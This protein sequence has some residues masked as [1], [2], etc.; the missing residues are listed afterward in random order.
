MAKK[1]SSIIQIVW[2][3]WHIYRYIYTGSCFSNCDNWERHGIVPIV[4][5]RLLEDRTCRLTYQGSTRAVRIQCQDLNTID[6]S[7]HTFPSHRSNLAILVYHQIANH[8]VLIFLNHRTKHI[9]LLYR[10]IAHLILWRCAKN[11]LIF[12]KYFKKLSVWAIWNSPF[13]YQQLIKFVL[14]TIP[15]VNFGLSRTQMC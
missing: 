12:K 13:F 2:N 7:I 8:S 15:T 14:K 9:I 3:S 5:S 11:R 10:Q 6:H 1:I 4:N